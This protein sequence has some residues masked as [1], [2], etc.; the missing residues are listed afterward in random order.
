[1]RYNKFDK[2]IRFSYF[3]PNG[4]VSPSALELSVQP[5]DCAFEIYNRNKPM[6]QRIRDCERDHITKLAMIRSME[7]YG[8]ISTAI[9]RYGGR[10]GEQFRVCQLTKSGWYIL[11]NTLDIKWEWERKGAVM[12]L[13]DNRYSSLDSYIP[14]SR[15][16]QEKQTNLMALADR[17]N[18]SDESRME[19]EQALIDAIDYDGFSFLA[20]EI[21]LAKQVNLTIPRYGAPLYRD[22]QLANINALFRANLYLTSID[23]LPMRP[24]SDP[25]NSGEIDL[26]SI[27]GFC[28]STLKN[29][30]DAHP[31]YL[32]FAQSKCHSESDYAAWKNT[33]AFYPFSQIPGAEVFGQAEESNIKSRVVFRTFLG[34]A[35]GVEVNYIVY[36]TK[37]TGF[38]WRPGIELNTIAIITESLAKVCPKQDLPYSEKPCHY[39]L[40]VTPTIQQ[41]AGIFSALKQRYGK[42]RAAK[43]RVCNPYE[44][45]NIVTL[46]AAGTMQIRLLMNKTPSNADAFIT[47]FMQQQN[48]NFYPTSD[49]LYPLSYKGYPV[50]I[51]HNLHLQHLFDAMLDYENGKKFY[52]ACYPE[53]VKYIRKIMPNVEFL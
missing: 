22:Y 35:T 13:T 12:D 1:M 42:N 38:N 17:K 28:K 19:F 2:K 16:Y 4:V 47:R 18:D 52:V 31:D 51:A 29:W 46:N 21:S 26:L 43:H 5:K 30:Y 50:L 48:E 33:P 40:I 6:S 15:A 44:A 37:P 11:T 41:F 49:S 36:H 53:Q 39:A 23:R 20:S 34:L 7:K 25:E 10:A 14:E 8:Y 24:E 32:Y 3:L 9:Y 45:I 27:P